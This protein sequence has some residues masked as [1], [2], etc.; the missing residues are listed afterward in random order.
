MIRKVEKQ[1][2]GKAFPGNFLVVVVLF[3]LCLLAFHDSSPAA[4][5]PAGPARP[6]IGPVAPPLAK[7]H[8]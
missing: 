4:E 1:K 8:R 2:T 3:L 7:C 5:S 6:K